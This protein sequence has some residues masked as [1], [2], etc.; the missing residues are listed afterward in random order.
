MIVEKENNL[1]Y[2][3]NMLCG[4]SSSV[5]RELPKLER[6]VRLPSSAP[7][8]IRFLR[9]FFIVSK[10]LISFTYLRYRQRF[11]TAAKNHAVAAV[12]TIPGNAA[13]TMA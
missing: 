10:L 13:A 6:R 4:C 3:T 2:D 5:E 9:I 7:L 11:S 8:R 12:N 1:C